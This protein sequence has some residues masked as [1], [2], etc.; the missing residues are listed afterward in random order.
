[1]LQFYYFTTFIIQQTCPKLH[2]YNNDV[3]K[4]HLGTVCKTVRPMLYIGPLSV[5]LLSVGL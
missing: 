5:G 2:I 1:V 4:C 3:V